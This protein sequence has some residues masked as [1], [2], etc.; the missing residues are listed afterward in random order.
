MRFPDDSDLVLA[1]Q[2]RP[3]CHVI[4]TAYSVVDPAHQRRPSH[5]ETTH[6]QMRQ[7]GVGRQTL[8]HRHTAAVYQLHDVR[9]D[10]DTAQTSAACQVVGRLHVDRL[11][12]AQHQ[13]VHQRR[14][15]LHQLIV[16]RSLI[17][18]RNSEEKRHSD[19]GSEERTP[20]HDRS[21][22]KNNLCHLSGRVIFMRG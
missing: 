4:T 10:H 1:M 21:P 9:I 17:D 22:S 16:L 7:T 13:T 8:T 5:A 3:H 15:E 20:G 2:R 11:R 19:E 14:Y 12:L 6:R 18:G